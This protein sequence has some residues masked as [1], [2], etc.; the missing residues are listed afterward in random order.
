MRRGLV[1]GR[2]DRDEP[3]PHVEGPVHLVARDL[4]LLL[5]EVEDGRA[6]PAALVEHR[7]GAVGQRA[8]DVPGQAAARDVGEG[9]HAHLL[10]ERQH[11]L[12]V[13]PR[14]D[15]ERLPER[16]PAE[17][18]EALAELLL[19]PTRIYARDVLALLEAVP[20]KSLAHVTGG[21]LPGNVPRN[22][23]EGTRAVLDERRWP[24]PPIFDLVQ[25][26]GGV[27]RA[28]MYRTFNLGLGL[29]AVVA[30]GDEAAAHAVLRERGLD[31]WTVGAIERGAGEASCEVVS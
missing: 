14:R 1:G 19:E 10:E 31:A 29:T 16:R 20:V 9:L 13:D 2:H 22:L 4:A 25:R 24:R 12:G 6:R 17:R 26:A 28:E 30:A 11:V 21:G 18:V 7:A 23:P 27:Q 3:E 8:R 15:E 5:D